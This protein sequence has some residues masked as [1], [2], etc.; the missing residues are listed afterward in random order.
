[1]R[2]EREEDA[3]VIFECFFVDP[4]SSTCGPTCKSRKK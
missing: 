3:L 4:E 2:G 1:M